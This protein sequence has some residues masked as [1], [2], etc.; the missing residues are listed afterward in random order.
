MS[1]RVLRR[2]RLF[3][4][5][6][7]FHSTQA[8]V[9]CRGGKIIKRY[10]TGRCDLLQMR[11]EAH[12]SVLLASHDICPQLLHF[13]EDENTL[14]FSHAGEPLTEHNAPVDWQEQILHIVRTLRRENIWHNDCHQNNFVVKDGRIRVIDLAWATV[15]RPGFPA[16][17]AIAEKVASAQSLTDAVPAYPPSPHFRLD[18]PPA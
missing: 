3:S 7:N 13:S 1:W 9:V 14:I 12:Y 8:S 4:K 5:R 17:N 10:G 11:N 6:K 16:L 2:M 15:G 18:F